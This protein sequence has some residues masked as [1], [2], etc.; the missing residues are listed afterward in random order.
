M[1]IRLPRTPKRP[2][3]NISKGILSS[4]DTVTSR[5]AGAAVFCVV[6]A[7]VVAAQEQSAP[8][9]NATVGSLANFDYTVRMNAARTLRR[10]PASVVVPAL[11]QA[12]RSHPD[13]FVRFRALVL[14]TGFPY[15]GM[16]D[17]IRGLLKDRNDRLRE[18]AYSWLAQHP[19]PALI[20]SL[21]IAL[22]TEGAEF[23][24]PALIKALTVV[25]TT[26]DVQRAL[27]A[28]TGRGLDFFRS[29]VIEALGDTRRSYALETI[30]AIAKVD[31][32]LQDDAVIA[33]GRIGDR[34]AVPTLNSIEK[35][36]PGL[37]AA[38]HAAVCLLG[39]DCPG[40]IKALSETITR[41]REPVQ[42]VRAAAA[43]LS[44]IAAG[45]SDAASSAL[46][47]VSSNVD[48]VVHEQVAV[49]LATAA[50]RN[51][52]HFIAWFQGL[53]ADRQGTAM[54]LIQDGFARLENDYAEEQ[55]FVAVRGAYW[56]AAEESPQRILLATL[57][58]KL[59]F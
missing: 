38:L 14:L 12:V 5:F 16:T 50:L 13:E 3:H 40:H 32:P 6:T 19:D 9:L 1:E 54:M 23:V 47:A 11:V 35:P 51:P 31:G 24:R 27:V 8:N 41:V 57:I 43:A 25:G 58:Q 59:D 7:I 4:A 18:A 15:S 56:K 49:A 22:Q 29:A 44:T 37:T 42:N 26:P 52:D 53:P 36:E 55:F 34:R 46:L 39:D 17:L 33:L 21:M 10:I 45:S 2:C 28:E 20:P 30:A 48:T